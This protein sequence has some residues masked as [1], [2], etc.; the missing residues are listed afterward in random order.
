MMQRLLWTATVSGLGPLNLIAG[1]P[2]DDFMGLL[3]KAKVSETSEHHELHTPG[4]VDMLDE[5]AEKP[6]SLLATAQTA[7]SK[8][9]STTIA[10]GVVLLI[11]VVINAFLLGGYQ[12][13]PFIGW[14]S[15]ALVVGA[16]VLISKGLAPVMTVTRKERVTVFL[17]CLLISGGGW[18]TG[19]RFDT[20]SLTVSEVTIAEGPVGQGGASFLEFSVFVTGSPGEVTMN[21]LADDV[22]MWTLKS[23]MEVSDGRSPSAVIQ[24]PLVD[25]MM[26]NPSHPTSSMASEYKITATLGELSTTTP[27]EATI[28]NR[29]ATDVEAELIHV[30]H[31]ETNPNY[32]QE[33][34]GER[35]AGAR[36]RLNIGMAIPGVTR[37]GAHDESSVNMVPVS[38]DYKV[39][40]ITIT[41]IEPTSTSHGADDCSD[42]LV[43]E[44]NDVTVNGEEASWTPEF[45]QTS[46][47][48][49]VGW[50]DLGGSAAYTLG[51]ATLE[52]IERDIFYHGDGCY[53]I[54]MVLNH[55]DWPDSHKESA[56]SGYEESITGESRYLIEWGAEEDPDA[57][58]QLTRGC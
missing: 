6:T 9:N 51:G 10:G 58:A 31:V 1:L 56:I 23:S 38:G 24:V 37:Q 25:I 42:T 34:G 50:L 49:D 11:S 43:W 4:G 18:L 45:T 44:H 2:L 21:V 13:I 35:Y 41:C 30:T 47:N 27:V 52:Y 14:I 15:L 53:S 17:V 32:D 5:K 36:L 7:E 33:G 22:V 48:F 26:E 20:E 40:L 19:F 55:L 54:T 39:S 28:M 29:L 16:S 12:P 3:D 57:T 46:D 8:V